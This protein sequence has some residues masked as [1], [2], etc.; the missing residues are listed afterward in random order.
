MY[1][2][3]KILCSSLDNIKKV[4]ETESHVTRNIFARYIAH[5]NLRKH[6]ELI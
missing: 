5:E 3:A 6:E 4:D 2:G 1:I